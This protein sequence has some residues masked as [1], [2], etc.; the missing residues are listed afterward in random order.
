VKA[1]YIK[2]LIFSV[3]DDIADIAVIF[4]A[5]IVITLSSMN[6]ITAPSIS[7]EGKNMWLLRSMPIATMDI[8]KSKIYLHM[9]ISGI[10]TVIFS[11]VCVA[12]LPMD[13]ASATIIPTLAVAS[14]F[15]F[16]MIGLA[17]NLKH[18]SFDWTNE[19]VPVKQGMS[20]FLT[21]LVG[22]ALS[23]TLIIT[24]YLLF[25]E[26]EL[27]LPASAFILGI[28]LILLAVCAF[29]WSWLCRRGVKIFE[30]L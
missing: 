9:L 27:Y 21:M 10:P 20:V 16:A 7:L 1:D 29:L 24:V 17:I 5:V 12:L 13:I 4:V 6:L 23:A 11:V 25:I 2:A 22:F 3:P 26:F 28:L 19:V 15:M 14:N 8:F 18:P 30:T